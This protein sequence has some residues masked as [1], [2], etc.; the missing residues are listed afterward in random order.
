M[1]G[2]WVVE[3][4]VPLIEPVVAPEYFI[5][6]P[7]GYWYENGMITVPLYRREFQA[8][9]P[10]APPS[11]VVKLRVTWPHQAL[12]DVINLLKRC[13][14]IAPPIQPQILPPGGGGGLHLVR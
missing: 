6:G 4:I 14:H 7:G 11:N 8:E 9:C 2:F 1:P 3:P 12:E 13:R 5:T 10:T